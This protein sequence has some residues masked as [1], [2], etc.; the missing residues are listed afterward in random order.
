[1]AF[2]KDLDRP[3]LRLS[4]VDVWSARQA[5]GG[6]HFWG[7][8]GQGKTSA[9]HIVAGAYLRAGFGGLVTA[10]KFEDISLWRRY[11]QQHGRKNS[12]IIFDGENETFNFLDYCM[13]RYGV[14]GIGTVVDCLM[15]V[16]DAARRASATASQRGGEAFWEDATRNVLRYTL[17]PLYSAKGSLNIL[18]ILRFISGAPMNLQEPTSREWQ[19]K[20]FMYKV[21]NVATGRPKVRMGDAALQNTIDYWR[22]QWPAVPDRTRGNIVITITAALDRFN[23]GKLNRAFCGRTTLVP[24]LSLC[25]GI[26]LLGCPTV[27]WGEDG[28]I[29]QQLLKFLWQKSVL[30]RNSLEE[31]H[32]ERFLFLWSDEAQD[33]VQPY[34]FEYLSLCRSSKCAVTYLTQSLPTYYSKIG[35]D[36]PRDAAMAL[37]GKFIGHV[38]CSNSCPDTNEF[39]ARTLGKVLARRG[40]FSA[41]SSQNFNEG[42]SVGNSKNT[43]SSSSYGSSSGKGYSFNSNSGSNT[44]AGSNSGNTRGRGSS[45]NVSRGY[46]ESMEYC[47]E[48]GDFGRILKTGGPQNGNEVT[49]VWFQ[50]GRVFKASDTNWLLARFAQ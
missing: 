30:N 17:P 16:V 28:L 7:G 35:G 4:P 44:G 12:L 19:E 24:E 14:D 8:I 22:Y 25:G 1:M 26:L 13:A 46:S 43:G 50:A 33:T 40:N 32:R 15:R 37:A 36:N 6:L 47:I 45:E 31:K 9:A 34:D 2:V 29:A 20:S 18:D 49:A 38:F 27:T 23:H 48:P 11:T 21:M 41:G 3:L 10:T 39:A 5:F 42:M